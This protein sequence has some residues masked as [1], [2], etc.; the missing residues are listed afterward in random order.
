MERHRDSFRDLI[1]EYVDILFGN[2]EEM[3]AL[4]Q[5]DSVFK[6]ID[7]GRND[8]SVLVTTLGSKG[9]VVNALGKSLDIEPCRTED[10]VDTTGAGDL[11]A[12][13]FLYGMTNGYDMRA[14]GMLGSMAAGE[15][16][17]QV[18][19]RPKNVLSGLIQNI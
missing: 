4:Y 3:I 9:S 2:E 7:R 18:G 14:S 10:V 15:I 12:A 13:G 17:K 16:I 11:Y 19:A 8:A 1:S 5:E 6:A